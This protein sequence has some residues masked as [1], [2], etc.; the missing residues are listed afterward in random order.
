MRTGWAYW[1]ATL[2]S[3]EG[4][5]DKAGR[6]FDDSPRKLNDSKKHCSTGRAKDVLDY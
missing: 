1:L 5:A 4:V 3:R 2:R 6:S